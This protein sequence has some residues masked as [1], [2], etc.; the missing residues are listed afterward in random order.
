MDDLADAVESGALTKARQLLVGGASP[1]EDEWGLPLIE[2]AI[3]RRDT[4]MVLLLVE[5]GANLHGADDK[6]RTRLH[7]AAGACDDPEP[8]ELLLRLGMDPRVAD[9]DGWTPLHYAAA[10]GHRRVAVSLV[11]AGAD[12]SARTVHGLSVA[13]LSIPLAERARNWWSRQ[14]AKFEALVG[15]SITGWSGDEMAVLEETA[16]APADWG[17]GLPFKQLLK[18]EIQ[19]GPERWVVKT[20]QDDASWGLSVDS[21]GIGPEFD[22]AGYRR[23]AEIDLPVGVVEDVRAAVE[24]GILTE[25]ALTVAGRQMLLIAGEVE[26][27]MDGSMSFCRFDESVLIFPEAADANALDWRP[28]RQ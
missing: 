2:V 15:R 19:I 10:Y 24:D 8:V 9:R 25:V 28:P 12:P 17:E 5:F 20:Y 18:L 13:D 27:E 16:S 26:P 23:L 3:E 22:T 4:A 11:E 6:G 14:S 21:G 7:S 1:I